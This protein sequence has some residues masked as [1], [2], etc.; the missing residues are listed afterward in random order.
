MFT[1]D[2][3]IIPEGAYHDVSA[4]LYAKLSL[5]QRNARCYQDTNLTIDP[6]VSPPKQSRRDSK[7]QKK[8]KQS[9]RNLKLAIQRRDEGGIKYHEAQVK[10]WR[11]AVAKEAAVA[12]ETKLTL[13]A[14][15]PPMR[16]S[17]MSTRALS[18]DQLQKTSISKRTAINPTNRKETR[19]LNRASTA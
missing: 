14:N 2:V 7:A 6:A 18:D 5:F 8:L 12:S 1:D 15:T 19:A 16:T 17:Q 13:S 4:D 11:E 3:V 10:I 9:N